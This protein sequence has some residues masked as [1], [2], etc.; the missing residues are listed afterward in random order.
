MNKTKA[1]FGIFRG[2]AT[3][4]WAVFSENDMVQ[5]C[6]QPYFGPFGAFLTVLRMDEVELDS[7]ESGLTLGTSPTPNP[8][9]LKFLIYPF[10]ALFALFRPLWTFLS[11]F[12]AF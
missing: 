4:N 9:I 7:H 6:G 1:V 10:R 5:A 12:G 3:G 2:N 11:P 8:V